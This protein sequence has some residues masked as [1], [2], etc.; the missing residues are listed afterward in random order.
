M[1]N[2]ETRLDLEKKCERLEKEN[3]AYN[4][5]IAELV[6]MVDVLNRGK[7]LPETEETHGWII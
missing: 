6:D 3:K 4:H 2:V 7:Q 1:S 5:V